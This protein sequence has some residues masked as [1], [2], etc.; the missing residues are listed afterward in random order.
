MT[1]FVDDTPRYMQRIVLRDAEANARFFFTFP[2]GK[3][4]LADTIADNRRQI[5]AVRDLTRRLIPYS[6]STL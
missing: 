6:S 1:A 5:A 2:Q 4:Y 3:A